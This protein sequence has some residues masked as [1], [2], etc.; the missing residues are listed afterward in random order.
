[1]FEKIAKWLEK[2]EIT[3]IGPLLLMSYIYLLIFATV[4]IA[5]LVKQTL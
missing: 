2:W 3:L 4:F 1:M 5:I